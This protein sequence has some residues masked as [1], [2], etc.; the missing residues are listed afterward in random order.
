MRLAKLY[1]M[2]TGTLVAGFWNERATALI[3][4]NT[5]G[6]LHSATVLAAMNT[7]MMDALIACH[8]AKYAYWV[9]RPKQVD[10]SIKPLI[11]VPNH[12]SYPSNHSCI[13]TTAALVLSHF[14][15]HAGPH[16]LGI[17]SDAGLSRIYAGLHFRFDV[18]AG[19]EIGRK[20]ATVAIARHPHLL[21]KAEPLE[22]A[23]R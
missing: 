15:P 14:F 12:P 6:E 23:D 2:T 20:V 16:L 4:G 17:A 11:G 21:T 1:D 22:S 9:P 8:D 19:E 13:S 18:D 3:R 10:P 5:V 7:A